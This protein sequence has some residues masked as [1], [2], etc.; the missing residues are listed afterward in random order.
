[1]RTSHRLARI[2]K[3][4][5]LAQTRTLPK[6][7]R[8]STTPQQRLHIKLIHWHLIERF[9]NGTADSA[10]LWDW[11]ETGFTYSQLMRLLAENDTEFTPEAL[12]AVANQFNAYEAITQRHQRTG[13]VGF[14]AVELLT[15]RAAASVL[16]SLI[17]LD[18]F[19]LAE[20]AAIWSIE[21]IAIVRR[22]I[23]AKACAA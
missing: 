14:N 19:G 8:S 18:R 15:A 12:A 4:A 9:T 2:I 13:H 7:W 1:M 16:E 20:K 22:Q 5:P 3:R 10:D 23:V 21:Q 11:I 6:F 17:D